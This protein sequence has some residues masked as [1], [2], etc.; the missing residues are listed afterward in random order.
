MASVLLNAAAATTTSHAV[1]AVH[2]VLVDRALLI[3]SSAATA[4]V[5]PQVSAD[6]T[7]FVNLGSPVANGTAV[8]RVPAS[9]YVRVVLT[10]TAG[11]ASA[12]VA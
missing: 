4:S 6:G 10:W 1:S 8:V 5:Q 11:T 3:S 9:L 7:T 12:W 2:N